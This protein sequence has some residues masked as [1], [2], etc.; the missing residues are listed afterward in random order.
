MN[1]VVIRAA[2]PPHL[3]PARQK[4]GQVLSRLGYIACKTRGHKQNVFLIS[5]ECMRVLGG[6][7]GSGSAGLPER[8][9]LTVRST[10]D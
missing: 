8:N 6:Q 7:C 3:A 9:K 4:P 10:T 1:Y 2:T 5:V